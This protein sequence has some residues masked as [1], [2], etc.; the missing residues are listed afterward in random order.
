MTDH[1][2]SGPITKAGD[3]GILEGWIDYGCHLPACF[4]G[5]VDDALMDLWFAVSEGNDPTLAIAAPYVALAELF[6]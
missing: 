4:P 3:A 6:A 1:V 5:K 2:Q